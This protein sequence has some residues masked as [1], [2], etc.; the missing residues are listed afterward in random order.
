MHVYRRLSQI[1]F[2]LL[3][4]L[5]PVLDIFRFDSG[6]G[7]LI[8]FGNEWGLGLKEGF[9][10]AP[11]FQ[12]AAHVAWRF[13]LKAVLPWLAVLAV[14]PALGAL[15]GRL[16][17][18]WS[19]PEGTLFE[20]FD[21]LTL[22]IFGRRN[23]FVKGE[24]DPG[25]PAENR[26]PYILPALVSITVIPVFTGIALTG[27]FVDPAVVWRQVI[28][29]EF[30]FGVKAGIIGVSIYVLVSSLIVRHTLCKYVCSAGLM[31][32]LFGWVSPVSLRIKFDTSR[33]SSCTDCK[34]CEKACFMN[35][36]PRAPR[37]DINCVNCG[38]CIEACKR[39]LG[40]EE[41]LFSFHQPRISLAPSE[42]DDRRCPGRCHE[43]GQLAKGG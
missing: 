16:F 8:V 28:G 27:Y 34:G 37:R 30:T 4:V 40:S 7:S 32:M 25:T 1:F 11:S 15:F 29:L 33:L 31:Q 21:F 42:S 36:K 22:K 20:L 23:L 26:L 18:G 39:E 41:G 10:L 2:I 43:S 17:C 3:I 5:V 9:H 24:N 19:C 38:E 35:V 12:N 6:S 13:F 14:F